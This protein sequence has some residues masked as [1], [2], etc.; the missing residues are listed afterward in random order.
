M[1]CLEVADKSCDA[2]VSIGETESGASF[3]ASY[4][5]HKQV[6]NESFIRWLK[7]VYRAYPHSVSLALILNHYFSQRC[8]SRVNGSGYI[9]A[10][11]YDG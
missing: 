5:E 2:S 3:L 6:L 8:T 10:V 9:G 1:F 4:P 11:D 7:Q